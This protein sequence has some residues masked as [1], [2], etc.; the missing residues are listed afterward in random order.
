MSS[1][2]SGSSEEY[3]GSRRL[4]REETKASSEAALEVSL[5][6]GAVGAS[7]VEGGGIRV[8]GDKAAGGMN[9]TDEGDARVAVGLTN[10]EG[11]PDAMG[12]T[13]VRLA[14]GIQ[15]STTVSLGIGSFAGRGVPLLSK[16]KLAPPD[17][18]PRLVIFGQTVRYA[19]QSP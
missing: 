13:G 9:T 11:V 18:Q 14:F 1:C 4:L 6:V 3:R 8:G 5:V 2:E 17:A 12:S 10:A 7:M 15:T 16:H 19:S